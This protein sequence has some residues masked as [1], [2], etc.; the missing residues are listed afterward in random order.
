MGGLIKLGDS[1]NFFGKLMNFE[2]LI[3]IKSFNSV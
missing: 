1:K 2:K 3:G